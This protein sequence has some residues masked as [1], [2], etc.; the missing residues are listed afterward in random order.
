MSLIHPIEER[1]VADP[2][3]GRMTLY[4]G[5]APGVGKTYAMLEAAQRLRRQGVDVIVGAVDTHGRPEV[6]DLLVGLERLPSR[7][8]E[9]R[10][11]VIE[12]FHLDAALVR[13]PSLVVVDDLGHVNAAGSRHN[14]RWHDVIDL[15]AAGVDVMSTLCVQQL[16]SQHDVVQQITSMRVRDP[17]PDAMFERADHVEFIDPPAKEVLTRLQDGK[18]NIPEQDARAAAAMYRK[19]SLLALREL[20]LRRMSQRTGRENLIYRSAPRLGAG[21]TSERILVCVDPSSLGPRL[22]RAAFRMATGLRAEWL[23]LYVETPRLALAGESARAQVGETLRLAEQLGAEVVHISGA[24][25]DRE[26]LGFARARGATRLIIGK[27]LQHRWRDILRGSLVDALVR[28][29]GDLDVHVIAGDIA[30]H[31]VTPVPALRSPIRIAAYFW[32]ALTVA[33]IAATRL[34]HLPLFYVI[35]LLLVGIALVGSRLGRGPALGAALLSILAVE[36]SLRLDLDLDPIDDL[37]RAAIYLGM[38]VL[39]LWVSGLTELSRRQAEAARVDER[40]LTALYLLSRELSQLRSEVD[41]AEC[42][43]RHVKKTMSARTVILLHGHDGELAPVA[44]TDVELTTDAREEGVARWAFEH[45]PAGRGTETLKAA[46]ALYLPLTAAGRTIGVLGVAPDDPDKLASPAERQL[47]D[48]MTGPVAL[49]LQRVRLAEEAQVAEVRAREEELRG[50]LLSSV[51]HDLRTPLASITGA[52]SAMLDSGDAIAFETRR[53]LLQTIYE[54]A[55]RL[56]R[57]VGNLLDMTRLEAGSVALRTDW[58][59]LEDPIG[60]ALARLDRR[61]AGREVQV[62]LQPDLPLL[63]LDEVLFEQLILNLLENA[64]KHTPAGS[65]MRLVARVQAGR[66]MVEV[67]DRGPGLPAGEEETIFEKFVR[68]SKAK[69]QGFGLGLAICRAIAAA[70]GG[71]ITAENRAGGGAVFRISLPIG[72]GPP[73]PAPDTSLASMSGPSGMLHNTAK[74]LLQQASGLEAETTT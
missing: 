12:E 63:A 42:A 38:L 6:A 68:G 46:Q 22:I 4:F 43:I 14:Q 72:A 74:I 19:N 66:V 3:R 59:A 54:E 50:S 13:R 10:G 28:G 69:T 33:T 23:A 32:A 16:E 48:A 1:S 7:T 51:S 53:D 26:I 5:A 24:R 65:P 57:L 41:I 55:E 20:A 15:L 73:E 25:I 8:V 60:S 64:C 36:T 11:K 49:A 37:Q 61:L 9:T 67:A 18:V 40:R 30:P 56:G 71:E 52:A 2:R 58:V 34:L 70:H 31:E 35:V 47:L 44:G 17:V 62:T 29:S 39:A 27:P 21:P 45:G